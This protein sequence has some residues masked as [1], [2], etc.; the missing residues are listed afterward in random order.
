MKPKGHPQ[1]FWVSAFGLG[2]LSENLSGIPPDKSNQRGSKSFD[3]TNDQAT[4][5]LSRSRGPNPAV[6]VA[7]KER[8]PRR[9]SQPCGNA[10]AW[11][12]GAPKGSKQTGLGIGGLVEK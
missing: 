5:A 8:A 2:A 1:H 12:R 7:L 11:R 10:T 4:L 3:D 6:L 9:F